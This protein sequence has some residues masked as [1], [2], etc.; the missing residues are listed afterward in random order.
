MIQGIHHFAIIASS[1]KSV[2]F[3]G[4]LGFRET[5]RKE[6]KNDTVVLMEGHGIQ[7]EMFIDA[8]H[9]ERATDPENIGLRHVALKVDDIQRTANELGI[10]IGPV[11]E[12]WVG[13]RYAYAKDPDGLPVELHE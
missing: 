6:R 11:M 10:E 7:I 5:F 1:E 8:N 3:Y 4:K 2:G 13:I 9:P 12:D